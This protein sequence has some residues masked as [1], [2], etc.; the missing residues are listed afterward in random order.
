M[1]LGWNPDRLPWLLRLRKTYN[2][3]LLSN[4]NE[5][6]IEW[7]LNDLKVHHDVTNFETS[8]FD[9]ICYSHIARLQ[10]PDARIYHKVVDQNNLD[11]SETIFIDDSMPNIKGAQDMGLHA[12]YHDPTLEIMDMLPQYIAN[13][14]L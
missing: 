4:T 6:H 10:K 8:Y 12:I 14:S 13:A 9:N 1:L 5:I 7:A 2:T 11:L 3:Y